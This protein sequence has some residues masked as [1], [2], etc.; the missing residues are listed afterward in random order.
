MPGSHRGQQC[1]KKRADPYSLIHSPV[2]KC[3]KI[4]RSQSFS[5]HAQT[6]EKEFKPNGRSRSQYHWNSQQIIFN[7][8]NS[9]RF[10]LTRYEVSLRLSNT[11]ICAVPDEIQ[12]TLIL[13]ELRPMGV[14]QIYHDYNGCLRLRRFDDYVRII[15][16]HILS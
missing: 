5:V 3:A 11:V 16:R 8:L 4:A 14:G 1:K 2:T 10:D 12:N 7:Q 13:S 15:H 9:I 6:S